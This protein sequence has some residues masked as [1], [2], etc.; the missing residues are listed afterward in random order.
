MTR[1][2]PPYPPCTAAQ[3]AA[4][5]GTDRETPQTQGVACL[6]ACLQHVAGPHLDNVRQGRAVHRLQRAIGPVD[7]GE[8]KAPAMQLHNQPLHKLKE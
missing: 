8:H 3:P 4:A 5:L 2:E 7:P 1:P 6:V